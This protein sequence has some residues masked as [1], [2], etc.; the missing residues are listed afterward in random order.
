LRNIPFDRRRKLVT[1]DVT[2]NLLA[3]DIENPSSYSQLS[4][5]QIGICAALATAIGDFIMFPIDTI[6]IIQQTSALSQNMWTTCTTT[7]A[8][9]GL[10]ALYQG[11]IPYLISEGLAGAL[12]LVTFEYTQ[13]YS[14]QH[15]PSKYHMPSRFLFA[16]MAMWLCSFIVVPSEVLKTKLQAGLSSSGILPTIAHIWRENGWR[17]FFVG[18]L[19]TLM[20]DIPYTMLELGIYENVKQWLTGYQP[21]HKELRKH[22]PITA[23]IHEVFAAA[24][25]GGVAASLTTPLDVVKTRLMTTHAKAS[26]LSPLPVLLFMIRD[27]GWPAVFVGVWA[28][29]VWLVPMTMIYLCVY[30]HLKRQW[31]AWRQMI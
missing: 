13:R 3:T 8:T 21:L 17:G 23:T 5:L 27:E 11:F 29:V 4:A 9:K 25:V 16:A 24:F 18:Y 28:R 1:S 7:I 20:R 31:L 6:K 19:A 12:K 14:A 30:E 26:H 22:W 10:S 2:L 15:I